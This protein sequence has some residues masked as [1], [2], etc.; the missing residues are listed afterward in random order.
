MKRRSLI[1]L[2]V[3]VIV[4]VA[5]VLLFQR[6]VGDVRPA[7]L[8]SGAKVANEVKNL[9]VPAGYRIGIFADGLSKAR[10]LQLSPE[11]V[12]LLSV[13]DQGRVVALPDADQNGAAD[14]VVDLLTGLTNPHGLAFHQG[15][16][17]VAEE[18]RVTR[19]N[20]DADKLAATQA[21]RILDLPAGGRH[22]TRSLAFA[23]GQLYVSLGSTCD[24]CVER[25]PWIGTVVTATPDGR[26]PRVF[27]KGLRNAVFLTQQDGQI[28]ATEMGRDFLGDNLPP[29]EI[30]L[31]KEGEDYGWPYCYGDR[32]SDGKFSADVGRCASTAAPAYKIAAHSAPLGL[33]FIESDQFETWEGDLLVALH[34]SWNRSTP[35][36]YKV[37]RITVEN[38]RMVGEEDFIS[39]FITGADAFGRPVDIEF[40]KAGSLY[41]S[42]DKA[43]VVYK[44]VKS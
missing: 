4:L 24:V 30:N 27:S 5:G 10:D 36:G 39:G 19:Y 2:G 37:I 34:G 1:W 35:I 9:K 12:L 38:G 26:N 21:Q 18:T 7:L 23:V 8:P 32:V 6:R 11:G 43:G 28:W 15:K 31:L 14:R 20:W 41:L 42:D 25:H 16:L 40:D 17:Y 29:D 33:A 13:Q 22:V 44:L 3:L